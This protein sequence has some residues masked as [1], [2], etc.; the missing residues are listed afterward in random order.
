MKTP[1]D[2]DVDGGLLASPK[3]VTFALYARS[4]RFNSARTE[5]EKKEET[6]D[7]LKMLRSF[8]KYGLRSLEDAVRL[9]PLSSNLCYFHQTRG[10]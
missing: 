8:D 1:Q 6:K 3:K 10:F 4:C 2:T 9:P 7:N 5:R